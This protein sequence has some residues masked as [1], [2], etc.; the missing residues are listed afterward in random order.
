[1]RLD[2]FVLLSP[3]HPPIR[4]LLPPV[5]PLAATPPSV[6][7]QCDSLQHCGEFATLWTVCSRTKTLLTV[8]FSQT[9][10]RRRKICFQRKICFSGEEKFVFQRKICFSKKN[11]FF[12]TL[13]VSSRS[14]IILQNLIFKEKFDFQRKML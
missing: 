6:R 8:S 4:I 9:S 12:N 14:R 11:L 7:V 10:N 5:F 1:M 2:L 3:Q 13:R